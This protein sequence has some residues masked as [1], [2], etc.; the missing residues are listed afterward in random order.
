MRSV[1]H[2]SIQPRRRWHTFITP[3]EPTDILDLLQRLHG[4][5]E[6]VTRCAENFRIY[7][8]TVA[9][10]DERV[11]AEMGLTVCETL[12]GAV[13]AF[14]VKSNPSEIIRPVFIAV[15]KARGEY[16]RRLGTAI[17]GGCNARTLAVYEGFAAVYAACV[18]AAESLE[19]AYVNNA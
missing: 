12:A 16:A 3:L 8:V 2:M 15:E 9:G 6:T 5:A 4:V 10:A 7:R 11:L 19:K 17:S 14:S 1:P 18:P 13:R